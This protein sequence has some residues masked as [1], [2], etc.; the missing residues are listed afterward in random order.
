MQPAMQAAGPR[1]GR[2]AVGTPEHFR[3]LD[4]VVKTVLVLNLIDAVL[5][6]LWVRLGLAREANALVRDLV[7]Q[8]ALAFVLVKLALVGL[9]SWLLWRRREH[10]LAVIGIF[11][12]FLAYYAVLLLHLRY[13]ARIVPQLV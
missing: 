4:G 11:A 12:A 8:H 1:A 7:E 9:G 2:L 3:W 10:P 13:L 5:T 6:L